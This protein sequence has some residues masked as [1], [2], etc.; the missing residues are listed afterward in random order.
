MSILGLTIDYGPF[1][2]M[3]Y[4]DSYHICNS[5]DDWG[6]YAFEEQPKVCKWNLGKL[7]ESVGKVLEQEEL[8]EITKYLEEEY[9]II[10]KAELRIIYKKKLG[11]KLTTPDSEFDELLS[12]L[13]E[14]LDTLHLDFTL[15]FYHLTHSPSFLLPS[16]CSSSLLL[17]LLP[18]KGTPPM[19]ASRFSADYISQVLSSPLLQSQLSMKIGHFPAVFFKK[20]QKKNLNFKFFEN[21]NE[22]DLQ[23]VVWG[24]FDPWR[25]KYQNLRQIWGNETGQDAQREMKNINPVFC[26][27]NYLMQEVIEDLEEGRGRDK[28]ELVLKLCKDPFNNQLKEEYPEYYKVPPKWA[29][30]LCLSCSS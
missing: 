12:S 25:S 7:I 23:N 8:K 17:S 5:S 9:E 2:M 30:E 6:R 27:R 24:I 11:L 22:N 3:E 26:L 28:L 13:F 29:K 1:G 18:S 10:Y 14:L 21:I 15:F 16:P 4:F 19:T 20:N